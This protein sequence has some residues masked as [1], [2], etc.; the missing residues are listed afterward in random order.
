M[1]SRPDSSKSCPALNKN[2]NSCEKVGHFAKTCAEVK[3]RT[4]EVSPNSRTTSA[5]KFISCLAERRKMMVRQG[6]QEPVQPGVARNA[7]LKITRG[8]IT[9]KYSTHIKGKFM[10]EDYPIPDMETRFHNLH[11]ASYFGE[12]DLSD[13]YYQIEWDGDAKKI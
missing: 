1:C 13:A 9:L 12:I 3:L 10:V 6:T 4:G 8:K 11:G 2:G 7:S 5:R